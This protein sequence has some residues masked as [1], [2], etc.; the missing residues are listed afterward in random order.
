MG[1]KRKPH[2]LFDL[3]VSIYKTVPYTELQIRGIRKILFSPQEHM[4]LVLIRSASARCFCWVP[5]HIFLWGNKETYQQF[6]IQKVSHLE[7]SKQPSKCAVWWLEP[8]W[9]LE[10]LWW[11][12]LWSLSK[13]LA[14]LHSRTLFEEKGYRTPIIAP[15]KALFSQNH[16]LWVLI[17][18]V[19]PRHF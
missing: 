2:D 3:F 4:L 10:P 16:M 9:W 17:K 6:S 11:L 19:M 14:K 1:F 18:S 7:L 13:M 8:W 15:D 12:E 5:Q